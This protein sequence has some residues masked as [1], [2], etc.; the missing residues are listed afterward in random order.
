MTIL[1]LSCFVQY[2]IAQK[3]LSEKQSFLNQLFPLRADHAT[4]SDSLFKHWGNVSL[5]VYGDTAYCDTALVY[6]KARGI[7]ISKPTDTAY[8]ERAV[9]VTLMGNVQIRKG[10][11]T[12]LS[13]D[14]LEVRYPE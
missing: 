13:A 12:T 1:F 14:R 2:A 4:M 3:G 10:D 7:N 11:G 8:I 6:V 5:L 9:S